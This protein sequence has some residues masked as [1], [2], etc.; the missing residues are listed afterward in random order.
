[1]QL[2]KPLQEQP[3]NYIMF[4][5][6][7]EDPANYNKDNSEPKSNKKFNLLKRIPL[8]HLMDLKIGY[9]FKQLFGNEKSKKITVVFLNAILQKAGR[10]PIKDIAFINI[11][12]GGEHLD[13]KQSRLD[14][15]AVTV[16]G[17]KINVEI[18]FIDKYDMV[19]RSIY[20]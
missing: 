10:E 15:L 1:M 14:I 6:I 3:L 12:A 18:Q 20:Y 8:H 11:G 7:K 5:T 16:T 2:T 9:A 4:D 19:K 17:E 13:D